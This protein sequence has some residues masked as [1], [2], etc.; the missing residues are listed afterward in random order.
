ML[1]TCWHPVVAAWSRLV[2]RHAPCAG[3]RHVS[4]E[5]S[6]TRRSSAECAPTCFLVQ[7]VHDCRNPK[8]TIKR[9]IFLSVNHKKFRFRLCLLAVPLSNCRWSLTVLVGQLIQTQPQNRIVESQ[10]HNSAAMVPPTRHQLKIQKEKIW[11]NQWAEM[12]FSIASN[13]YC[14]CMPFST[15]KYIKIKCVTVSDGSIRKPWIM[16]SKPIIRNVIIASQSIN[17]NANANLQ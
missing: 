4:W 6:W 5:R 2:A 7:K 1:T 14:C 8:R 3:T 15:W 13:P 16:T 9:T 11:N 10:P 17:A 12:T